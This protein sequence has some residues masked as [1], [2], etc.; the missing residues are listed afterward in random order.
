MSSYKQLVPP[1]LPKTGQTVVQVTGDDGTQQAGFPGT[2][3]VDLNASAPN[4]VRDNAL[5]S[6]GNFWPKDPKL[7][8]PGSSAKVLAAKGSYAVPVVANDG[9]SI[10]STGGKLNVDATGLVGV[11]QAVLFVKL[12]V[13]AGEGTVSF[14]PSDADRTAGTNLMGETGPVTGNGTAAIG[15]G[16]L[17][18]GGAITTTNFVSI[19]DDL[20]ITITF[21]QYTAGD[22]VRDAAANQAA[23]TACTVTGATAA[24]PCVV[25]CTAGHIATAGIKSGDLVRFDGIVGNMGTDAVVGL[26][27]AD[28]GG[29]SFY[30]VVSG[31]TLTLYTN[32]LCTTKRNTSGKT[33]TSDGTATQTK[34]YACKTTHWAQS[35]LLDAANWV[36]TP[37]ITGTDSTIGNWLPRAWNFTDAV[38]ACSD[39]TAAGLTWHGIGPATA[40]NPTGWRLPNIR[41]LSSVGLHT[42]AFNAAFAAATGYYWSATGAGG[43]AWHHWTSGTDGQSV[44]AGILYVLPIC[45]GVS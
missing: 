1:A 44:I 9:N 39:Y 34:F 13:L 25:T 42:G 7:I 45:G 43:Y 26:N 17:S 24:D 23:P 28:N 22:V 30:V 8:I 21:T 4:L 3:F 18:L 10:I 36:F 20:D 27:Y 12:L 16:D 29:V 11:A 15:G 5:H 32:N 40:A 2:R 35:I 37:W 6:G 41:E 19:A 31:N 33:Y 38:A 14:Y